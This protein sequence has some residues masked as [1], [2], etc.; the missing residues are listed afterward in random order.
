MVQKYSLTTTD[1]ACTA[2]DIVY[3]TWNISDTETETW[4]MPTEDDL[5]AL[6]SNT[7]P[8]WTDNYNN[9]SVAGYVLKGKG[10]YVNEEIFLPAAGYDDGSKEHGTYGGYWSS[11]P[12]TEGGSTKDA[13]RMNFRNTQPVA[14]GDDGKSHGHTIRPV[15]K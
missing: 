15:C 9:T 13:Y 4:Q 3:T 1:I 2:E 5:A 6:I 7:T 10:N 12:Y 14:T 8:E 11:T